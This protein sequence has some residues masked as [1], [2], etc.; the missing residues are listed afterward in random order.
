MPGVSL[1]VRRA[2]IRDAVVIK[3]GEAGVVATPE[4]EGDYGGIYQGESKRDRGTPTHAAA[5]VFVLLASCSSV[6]S[7]V[8]AKHGIKDPL[9]S[10]SM[11]G[12]CTLH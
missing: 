7:V 5:V 6:G 10:G 12:Y 11:E 9:W 8:H 2:W 4:Q 1:P 3:G